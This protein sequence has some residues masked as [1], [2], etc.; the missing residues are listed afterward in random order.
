MSERSGRFLVLMVTENNQ[1]AGRLQETGDGAYPLLQPAPGLPGTAAGGQD[2]FFTAWLHQAGHDGPG[3]FSRL[4]DQHPNRPVFLISE[5]AGARRAMTAQWLAGLNLSGR[6]DRTAAALSRAR[7]SETGVS[8]GNA[9]KC[10]MIGRSPAWMRVV[11]AARQVAPLP[12]TVLITGETGTG[13][14]VVARNVHAQSQR[15]G[16]PFIA[17]SCREFSETLLETELFGHERGAFTGAVSQRRGVFERA[18]GGTLFLDEITEMSAGMQAKLLRVI[19]GSTFHRVGGQKPLSSD[20]RLI[21]AANRDLE[22]EVEAGRFRQDLYYRLAVFPVRLPP[23]RDRQSD[24]LPLT[25]HFL[26]KVAHRFNQP[27][28]TISGPA[29]ALL[30]EHQWPGNVRELENLIERAVITAEGPEINPRDIHPHSPPLDTP[31]PGLKLREM[32]KFIIQLALNRSGN[33]KAQAAELLGIARKT[34]SDKMNRYGLNGSA[35]G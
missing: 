7:S 32:E 13:K 18:D 2:G 17:V 30:F 24:I 6:G 3:L 27:P 11:R 1:S 29:L 5:P 35:G 34:L 20:F 22:A 28:R 26:E 10:R 25:L 21:V 12:S 31:Q 16:A 8:A 9:P 4:I 33:N 23:L 15:S 19:E 14:E